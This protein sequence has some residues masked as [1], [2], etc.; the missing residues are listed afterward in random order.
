MGGQLIVIVR[1][2]LALVGVCAL[3]WVVLVLLSR[4]GIGVGRAG[5]RL[6]VLERVTLS[7]R[8]QVYLVRA[9]QH[10]LVVGA[11]EGGALSLL[12]E[13]PAERALSSAVPA[14]TEA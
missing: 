12:L 2:L 6:Q 1:T 11:G 14:R 13:L 4:R 3:A 8:R 7:P 10:V 5:G 9:D